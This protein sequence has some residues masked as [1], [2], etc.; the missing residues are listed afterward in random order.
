MCK[1]TYYGSLIKEKYVLKDKHNH[2]SEPYVINIF[3]LKC[4]MVQMCKETTATNKE[5]FDSVSRKKQFPAVAA[6]IS[7][8]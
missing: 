7:F 4:E 5:I 1:K 2:S 8:P 3:N 6:N